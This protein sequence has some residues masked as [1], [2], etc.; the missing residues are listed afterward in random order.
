R[1]LLLQLDTRL[2]PGDVARRTEALEDEH[3]AVGDP[4]QHEGVVSGLDQARHLASHVDRAASLD[5]RRLQSSSPNVNS[6]AYATCAAAIRL[7]ART[8]SGAASLANA[9][10]TGT[11]AIGMAK[12][13][14]ITVT[15][16]S[17]E[18]R[19]TIGTAKAAHTRTSSSHRVRARPIS[20]ASVRLPAAASVS[21]SRRLF[22]TGIAV[23]RHPMAQ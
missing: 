22:M 1:R 11:A 8:R 7:S 17:P 12:W 23:A 13:T 14:S 9:V 4:A 20:V 10:R 18:T 21:M 3:P 15:P 16:A 2:E 6:S 5:E 19:T